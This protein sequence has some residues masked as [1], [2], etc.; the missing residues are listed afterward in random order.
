MTRNHT[1]VAARACACHVVLHQSGTRHFGCSTRD[2]PPPKRCNL[3]RPPHFL[4]VGF[5]RC[6]PLPVRVRGF[7]A[8][9]RPRHACC[10]SLIQPQHAL[11]THRHPPCDTRL[12]A[13]KLTSFPTNCDFVLSL[14]ALFRLLCVYVF[15]VE[16]PDY[17]H[18]CSADREP[19][20]NAVFSPYRAM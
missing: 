4:T 15:I 19:P 20:W 13:S 16:V 8:C 11:A 14:V 3:A 2:C 12:I 17:L 5:P 18:P 7:H 9:L 1:T 10:T 6:F